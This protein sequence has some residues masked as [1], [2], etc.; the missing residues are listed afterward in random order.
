[1]DMKNIFNLINGSTKKLDIALKNNLINNKFDLIK[2]VNSI[3]EPLSLSKISISI[4]KKILLKRNYTY[5]ELKE[6]EEKKFNEI[7][8]YDIDRIQHEQ[9][10][11]AINKYSE[12]LDKD[13][14]IFIQKICK[15]ENFKP[16]LSE[17]TKLL[18]EDNKQLKSE[19]W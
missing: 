9:D 7:N 14:D 6:Q 4:M 11:K 10:M 1:M 3:E 2:I 8:E 5:Y 12:K 19:M 16:V 17:I 18:D 15:F 13:R